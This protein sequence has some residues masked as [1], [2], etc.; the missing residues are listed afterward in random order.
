MEQMVSQRLYLAPTGPLLVAVTN[1]VRSLS[2]G[3]V[4]LDIPA[5]PPVLLHLH[6]QGKVLSQGVLRGPTHLQ[7]GVGPHQ[8]VGT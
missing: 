7:Q 8:K 5:V 2:N 4:L 3:K 6:T 1:L